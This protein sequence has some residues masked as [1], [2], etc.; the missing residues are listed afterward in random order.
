MVIK[1]LCSIKPWW[2]CFNYSTDQVAKLEL[3]S[4]WKVLIVCDKRPHK[5]TH[6][7]PIS[8]Q[9]LLSRYPVPELLLI[10]VLFI[11]IQKE[12]KVLCYGSVIF[13]RCNYGCCD[14]KLFPEKCIPVSVRPALFASENAAGTEWNSSDHQRNE[15]RVSLP[16]KPLSPS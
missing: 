9:T 16:V 3:L 15:F 13:R 4:I 5:F 14:R 11:D 6:F 2:V 8:S 1:Y 12:L 7:L 10:R